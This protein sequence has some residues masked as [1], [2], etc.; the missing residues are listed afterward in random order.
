MR[1]LENP[2][3]WT[4]DKPKHGS[5]NW[6]R[7]R[8]RNPL[9]E[10]LISASN[11]AVVHGTHRFV[12]PAELALDLLDPNDPQPVPPNEAMQRGQLLEPALLA[13]ADQQ[14][15]TIPFSVREPEL[16]YGYKRMV[17][18]LDG[19]AGIYGRECYPVECKTTNRRWDGVLP[20]YW[21]WQGVQQAM[22]V[23]SWKVFW[24]I[25]DS[26]LRFHLHEQ[27]VTDDEKQEHEWAV[28]KFLAALDMGMMPENAVL[29]VED[30]V[31]MHPEPSS[32]P[33]ELPENARELFDWYH[34][35]SRQVQVAKQELDACKAEIAGLLGSA[36]VGVLDGD[37]VV[38]WKVAKRFSF[39]GAR[40]ESEH[41]D[42]FR[43]Y[44]KQTTYRTMRVKG[45]K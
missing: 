35:A 29:T 26:N 31:R 12:T 44:Q 5:A 7:L 33:V 30:L 20:D 41:P 11:A 32:V 9:G 23:D 27:V 4:V 37:E 39:D 24:V 10:V 34:T 36:E 8:R 14:R 18:T 6:L 38:T 40:F 42:M 2:D 15:P 17:S 3:Y 22:C 1:L 19:L 45:G 25:L 16:M 43:A 28:D 21:R 13:W